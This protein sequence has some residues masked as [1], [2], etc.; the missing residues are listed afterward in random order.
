M[1]LREKVSA[2]FVLSMIEGVYKAEY[3]WW[4]ATMFVRRLALGFVFG[5]AQDPFLEKSLFFA[6]CCSY[7][8]AHLYFQPYRS[9][10]DNFVEFVYLLLLTGISWVATIGGFANS[11]SVET[12]GLTN[13]G[14]KNMRTNME[15][16]LF[17]LEGIMCLFGFI[18]TA[19]V[20]LRRVFP[21]VSGKVRAW[22]EARSKRNVRQRNQGGADHEKR[23]A[24]TPSEMELEL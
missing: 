9:R 17:N 7:L 19:V 22:H 20:V 18:L 14:V 1:K 11:G 13:V 15:V 21:I 10:A 8:C 5:F 16:F 2:W 24:F 3:W 6:L 12:N 4:E 23:L